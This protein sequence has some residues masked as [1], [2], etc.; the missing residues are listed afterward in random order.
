ML[1]KST[2]LI[3]GKGPKFR[4]QPVIPLANFQIDAQHFRMCDLLFGLR[5]MKYLTTY[6]SHFQL[7]ILVKIKHLK[8]TLG[9]SLSC[10]ILLFIDGVDV[11]D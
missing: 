11:I 6:R 9:S 5:S 4:E 7:S 2:T 3:G 1:G 8:K 10:F